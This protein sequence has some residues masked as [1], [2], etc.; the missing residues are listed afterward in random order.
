MLKYAQFC[1]F[2]RALRK[3]SILR[4]AAKAFEAGDFL[5]I[6]LRFLRLI[7]IYIKKTCRDS[8]KTNTATPGRGRK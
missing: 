2:H 1:Y 5:N 3:T 4:I 7:F 8:V 6:F